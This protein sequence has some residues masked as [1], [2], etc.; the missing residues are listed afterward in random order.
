MIGATFEQ[1]MADN[2]IMDDLQEL[3]RFNY[4]LLSRSMDFD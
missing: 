4:V 3:G 2:G 1:E